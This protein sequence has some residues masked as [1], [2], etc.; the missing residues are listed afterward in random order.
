M[1][2]KPTNKKVN[3]NYMDFWHV[4]KNKIINNWVMVDFQM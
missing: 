3:I 1:G 2:I 4:K